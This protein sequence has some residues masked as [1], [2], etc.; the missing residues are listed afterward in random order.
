MVFSLCYLEY[1]S[2]RPFYLFNYCLVFSTLSLICQ[3]IL[4]Y[5]FILS[6]ILFLIDLLSIYCT[7]Y[8]NKSLWISVTHLFI[9][10]FIH[11]FNIRSF[12][13]YL[14][15]QFHCYLDQYNAHKSCQNCWKQIKLHFCLFVILL[16][17]LLQLV[18]IR[19][20]D[21]QTTKSTEKANTDHRQR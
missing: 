7:H 16:F 15:L 10:L 20:E 11:L 13:F 17:L 6:H 2:Y 4:F 8:L 9:Y 18:S 21:L 12:F 14:K 1:F 3:F 5:L 19:N